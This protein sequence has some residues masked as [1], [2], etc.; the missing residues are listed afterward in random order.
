MVIPSL[1]SEA[2]QTHLW[3]H[4][5]PRPTALSRLSYPGLKPPFPSP[6]PNQTQFSRD[7]CCWWCYF[8][9]KLFSI[10]FPPQRELVSQQTHCAPFSSGASASGLSE[11][12]EHN[13]NAIWSLLLAAYDAYLTSSSN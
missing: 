10:Y 7:F 1:M 5:L 13:T 6:S 4:T 2:L 9:Q 8:I 12:T 11:E 3:L